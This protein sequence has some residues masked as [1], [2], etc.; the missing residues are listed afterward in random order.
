MYVLDCGKNASVLYNSELDT[1][2]DNQPPSPE[3]W[4]EL[5]NSDVLNLHKVL[6]RGSQLRCEDPHLG[7]PRR[8]RSKAQPWNE[9][10]LLEY[11]DNLEE[12]GIELRLTPAKST[13]RAQN[14]ARLPKSDENDAKSIYLLLRDYPEIELKKPVLSFEPSKQRLESYAWVD[15]SNLIL[16]NQRSDDYSKDNCLYIFLCKHAQEIFDDLP[17]LVED[18]FTKDNNARYKKNDKRREAHQQKGHINFNN[19]KYSQIYSVLCQLLDDENNLRLRDDGQ[20]AGWKFIKRFAIKMTPHHL[21]GGVARSNIYYHGVRHWVA[22]KAAEQLG[23]TSKA[24]KSKRRGGY[25]DSETG[26]YVEPMTHEEE[27]A[28]LKYRR[29]YCKAVKLLFIKCKEIIEREYNLSET[30]NGVQK[31]IPALA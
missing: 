9:D 16:N 27:Q 4:E 6:P 14:R 20:L 10:E 30:N 18:V 22:K 13:P 28:Y 2:A 17:S 21:K 12:A 5:K 25:M 8:R 11:Y 7:C 31:L 23:M 26:K 15:E 3:S 29:Q 19:L 24:F 1:N